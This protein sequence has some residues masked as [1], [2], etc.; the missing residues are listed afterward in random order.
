MSTIA[1]ERRSSSEDL[2]A[3][4]IEDARRRHR[5]RRR[6]IVACAALA[7]AASVVGWATLERPSG[8]SS[9]RHARPAGIVDVS[10]AASVSFNV[11][12]YPSLFVGR[13]GW[14]EAVEEDGRTGVSACGGVATVGDPLLISMGFGRAGGPSTTVVVTTPE[15]ASVLVDGVEKVTPVS[16]PGLPYGLRA[17][18]VVT[19]ANR[20]LRREGTAIV[21]YDAQG[22]VLRLPRNV[23]EPQTQVQFWGHPEAS[24]RKGRR[25][26]SRILPHA[27]SGPCRLGLDGSWGMIARGGAV[28]VGIRPFPAR[29]VGEAF[30]PCAETEYELHG[31]PLRGLILL[32]A[33]DPS[34]APG[35]LPGFHPVAGA[36]GFY[37][38]G[39]TLTARR[40]GDAW[41][42]V[43]QGRS[44]SQRIY[45]LRHLRA[46]VRL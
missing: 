6:R 23:A 45:A 3:G 27:P 16:V 2:R 40:A 21:A 11:R 5:H 17:A 34:R 7:V 20:R 43:G 13:A 33:A 15:V 12:L 30:L 36:S 31:E 44:L 46:T 4:V 8:E 19:P 37:A 39:G 18:R 25:R 24:L 14:C 10:K 26:G 22:H 38:E 1:P 28:A 41:L 42:V 35:A 32:D 9:S 29:L